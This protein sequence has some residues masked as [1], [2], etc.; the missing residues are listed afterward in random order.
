MVSKTKKAAKP[1]A[2]SSS[3]LVDEQLERYRAMRDFSKTAEPSGQE[4]SPTKTEGLPFVIQKH[5]ATRLHY[6]FRLGLHGV[7]KSWAVTK[8]PSYVPGDKRLAVQVEDHPM[9]YGGFEGT[10]PKG[11]YGGGTVMLWDEG[12]W[13]PLGDA[14]QSLAKGNLKFVLH[15]KKLHGKWVLVRMGGKAANEAKPNWLLIKEHDEY[16]QTADDEPITEKAPNSVLTERDIDAIAREGDHVWQSNRPETSSQSKSSPA[17]RS[18]PFAPSDL[19]G[20]KEAL[21]AFIPPQLASEAAAP[22]VGEHWVHELKLDGYRMQAHID[23]SGKVRLYTRSGLDWTHRMPSIAREVGKLSVESAILDGEVVVL[24]EDGQSSFAKLQAAFDEGAAH[25]LTYFVF[26]LMHLNGHDLRQQPLTARK[27]ILAQMLDNLPEHETVRYGQHIQTEGAP[28]F[29]EACRLGAEGIV[30]KRSDSAYTSGRT[31]SWLKIKCD[32][33]QEF[34]VGGF[35]KPANGTEGIGALLLGYY[36][37]KKLIYAGRT[38]TGFTQVN[39]RKLRQQLEKMRQTAMPFVEVPA[40]AGKGALWVRPELVAEVQFSTWTADNLV[41]QASFKGLREDKKAA[42]VRREVPDASLA[43]K[44]DPPKKADPAKKAPA[45][46]PKKLGFRVTHPD[47]IVDPETGL[48]KQALVDYYLAVAPLMLPHVTGRPLSLVRCPNGTGKKCFYQKHLGPGMPPGIGG[49]EIPDRKGKGVETYVTVQGE[50]SLAGLA[51]MN[52]LEIHPWGSTNDDLE[53][54]DRII[55]DLDPDEAVSWPTLCESAVEVRERL[56]KLGL[57][58]F[59]KTTGGKGLH[60]VAPIRPK[61][62]WERIKAFTHAFTLQME[63]D[64]SKLY[65]SKMTK[66]ARTNKI[67][68]DYL[69]NEWEATAVAPYSSRARLGMA[70]A[71]PLEWAELK[72]SKRPKFVIAQFGEWSD[73]MRKD[74]WKA[75]LSSEQ[76]IPAKL[77]AAEE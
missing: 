40:S 43:Q 27:E 70:A 53:H 17:K 32:R 64:N 30:S 34:V 11:Q 10:I 48:T 14:D 51:Q 16:E 6:D 50:E 39:S 59:V 46:A 73:R 66:A 38:G 63:Q 55:F 45:P 44:S 58:S 35:T 4:T 36:D 60:V 28:I 23:K 68:V 69:R 15:G 57:Q 31:K 41:R 76:E 20:K 54:P 33:R 62:D 21:P 24:A 61:F 52:V 42:E 49:V 12:T 26:D 18:T 67:F 29:K 13:E 56:K 75:M 9:E 65:I 3:G 2:A 37:N 72:S 71:L 8:G 5:A 7:L 19:P 74:P 77:F 22:P 1:G 25:P 47:K